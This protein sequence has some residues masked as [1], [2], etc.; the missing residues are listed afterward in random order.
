MVK[1]A[2]AKPCGAKTLPKRH[3]QAFWQHQERSLPP[4]W[5][6]K[7]RSKDRQGTCEDRRTHFKHGNRTKQAIAERR[8]NAAIGR[9]IRRELATLETESINR[10]LLSPKWRDE[11]EL[12]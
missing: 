7:H 5:R 1:I 4:S 8:E 11:F 12:R 2:N 9:M 3:L 6:Q 10:G